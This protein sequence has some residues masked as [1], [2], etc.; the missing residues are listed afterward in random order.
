VSRCVSFKETKG[1]SGARLCE[2]G[3]RFGLSDA[4]VSQASRRMRVIGENDAVVSKKL[5]QIKSKLG[6]LSV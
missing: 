6:L 2:I 3:E 5:E 1:V 4:A